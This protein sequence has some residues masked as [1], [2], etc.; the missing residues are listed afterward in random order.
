MK[1]ILPITSVQNSLKS[2][3]IIV[4]TTSDLLSILFMLADCKMLESVQI[5]YTHE[6]NEECI[7]KIDIAKEEIKDKCKNIMFI[8]VE[9]YEEPILL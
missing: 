1:L 2:I 5:Y 8:E 9:K 3:W 7:E 6:E 4:F